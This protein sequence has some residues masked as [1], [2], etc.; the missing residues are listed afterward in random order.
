MRPEDYYSEPTS[1]I[2]QYLSVLRARKWTVILTILL[3]VTAAIGYSFLQTPVYTAEARILVQP[4]STPSS[5]IAQAV[6]VQTE[7]QVIDSQPVAA[8]VQESLGTNRSVDSLLENLNVRGASTAQTSFSAAQV[9][10]LTFSST[11]ATFAR[12][13]VNSFAANYK[14]YRRDQ[15]LEIFETARATVQR[16]LEA[17]A[18]QMNQISDQLDAAADRNDESLITALETQRGV[19][20]SRMGVLQ[21]RLDDLQPDQAVRSG[22]VESIAAASTPESPSSPN[23]M[24]SGIL[25]LFAGILLGIILAM[26]RERLDDRFR[27][28]ADVEEVLGAPVL[29]TVPRFR[30]K[31][32]N[33]AEL[34]ITR[35]SKDLVGEAYRTLRTNLQFAASQHDIRSFVVTSPSA[36]EGKTVTSSNLSVVLSQAGRR[37]IL[38]SADLRRP[39]I[40][41]Y[42]SVP[43]TKGL[44][45]YLLSVDEPLWNFIA[46][47]GIPNLRLLPSGPVPGNPAELLTT[48]KMAE[49]LR[50]LQANCDYLVIDSPPVLP[51][52]DAAIIASRVKGTILVFDAGATHRSATVHARHELER[53]GA[54]VLGC[55]MNNYDAG[56]SSYYGGYYSSYSSDEQAREQPSGNGSGKDE[57]SKSRSIFGTRG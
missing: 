55:V 7:S 10:V 30:T 14:E 13:A 53:G 22:G 56:T 41:N 11:D 16:R 29:A 54:I 42:F 45:D 4:L 26:V 39:T 47:P 27:G 50:T 32:K 44:A 51:V 57:R 52:A 24:R 19:L 6:D 34:L 1:D 9:V 28:R 23:F 49:T 17:A 37:V 25:A 46:D 12:D 18:A 20:I 15:A 3:T 8:L 21:Q 5:T 33:P 2:R 36:R 38:V 43:N 35:D 40:E 31:R 48:G